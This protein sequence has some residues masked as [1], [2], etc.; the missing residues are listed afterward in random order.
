MEWVSCT[1]GNAWE[2]LVEE[3][4]RCTH[5][6]HFRL[7]ALQAD[8]GTGPSAISWQRDDLP[9]FFL[10]EFPLAMVVVWRGEQSR[11]ARAGP[12]LTLGCAKGPANGSARYFIL[13]TLL[14]GFFEELYWNTER[15]LP[16]LKGVV[17]RDSGSCQVPASRTLY[18]P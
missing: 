4:L 9:I 16:M 11:R 10:L 3:T 17:F 15:Q 7:T 1:D 2:A 6:R 8:V 14:I 18:R 5:N 12:R 13:K